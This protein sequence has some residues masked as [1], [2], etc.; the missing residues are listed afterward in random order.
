MMKTIWTILGTLMA[1]SLFAQN[2]PNTLPPVPAPVNTPAA[3][4]APAAPAPETTNTPPVKHSGARR[5]F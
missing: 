2:N 3:E 5:P 4:T 1:A